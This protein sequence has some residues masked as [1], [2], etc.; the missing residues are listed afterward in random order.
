M[1]ILLVL[2]M[3]VGAV[4]LLGK[5]EVAMQLISLGDLTSTDTGFFFFF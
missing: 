1:T 3:L 5:L 2:Y 4:I